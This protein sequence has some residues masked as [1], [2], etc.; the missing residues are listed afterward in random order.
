VNCGALH[1]IAAFSSVLGQIVANYSVLQRFAA[2]CG[3]CIKFRCFVVNRFAAFCSVLRRFAANRGELQR[4]AAFCGE[5]LLFTA[6]C[7]NIIMG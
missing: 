7:G 3:V 6:N 1:R 4:I 2:K 5:L